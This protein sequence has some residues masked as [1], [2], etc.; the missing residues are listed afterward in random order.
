MSTLLHVLF[1]SGEGKLCH[2]ENENVGHRLLIA[3]PKRLN[4]KYRDFYI[5]FSSV[6]GLHWKSTDFLAAC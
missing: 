1:R 2:F 5:P 3:K 6:R 4:D